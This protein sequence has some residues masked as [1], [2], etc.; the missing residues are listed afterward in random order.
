MN[1]FDIY[2]DPILFKKRNGDVNDP[3]KELTETIYIEK[4]CAHLTEIPNRAFGVKVTS[5]GEYM[6][7]VKD[8]PLKTNTYSVNYTNGLV[9]FH[10]SKN[11]KSL[12]FSYLGEGV[13]N[14][15]DSRIYLTEDKNF[16]TAK[17]KFADIDRGITEQKNRV[18]TLIRENPQPSE[19]VDMRIDRNGKVYPVA[20]DRVDAEQLKIE[21]LTTEINDS[22]KDLSGKTYNT[23]KDYHEHTEKKINGLEEQGNSNE[24]RIDDLEVLGNSNKDRI[25]DLEDLENSFDYTKIDPI[26]FTDLSLGAGTVLQWFGIDHKTGNMYATQVD[27]RNKNGGERYRL[28]RMSSTGVYLDSMLIEKGG[29]G[30]TV[31]MEWENGQLYFW[32]HWSEIDSSKK[33]VRHLVRFPYVAN[34]TLNSGVN[35]YNKFTD[36][37]VTPTIDYVNNFILFRV[38]LGDGTQKLELRR[39]SDVKNGI[40]NVLHS[41]TIPQR[42]VNTMQG[43][44]SDGYDIYWYNGSSAEPNNS[45]IIK[46]DIRTGKEIS[47]LN[48]TFGKGIDG[49]YKDGFREPEGIFIYIDPKTKKKSLFAGVVVGEIT[50]RIS[51]IYGFHQRGA[52]S[53]FDFISEV[54]SQKYPLTLANGKSIPFPVSANKISDVIQPGLYYMNTKDT[55]RVSDHPDPGDA[56]WFLHVYPGDISR[57]VVQK[58][59]RNSVVRSLRVFQRG[60]TGS[61]SVGRWDTVYTGGTAERLGSKIKKL[62]NCITPGKYYITNDEGLKYS[63]HP[64]PGSGGYWFDVSPTDTRDAVIQTMTLNSAVRG[65]IKYIRVV[66]TTVKQIGEW[67][68]MVSGWVD[69]KS[70][71]FKN[72]ASGD[73]RWGTDGTNLIIRGFAKIPDTDG[74]VFA[75][76]PKEIAP[77]YYWMT[78][79]AVTGTTGMRKIIYEAETRNLIASGIMAN[80][81]QNVDRVSLY[82]TIPRF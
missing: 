32:S 21:K 40:N 11:K 16:K 4:C 63:D 52:D 5:S 71:S 20:K 34:T 70:V 12:T 49:K 27:G 14:Y 29:H 33:E 79:T 57:T 67:Q 30:T 73:C 18:D 23:L 41:M 26:F 22:K 13:I 2:N 65:V 7:E 50:K 76:V 37:Y 28:T 6:Y 44:A 39:L 25:E 58:I 55:E 82:L 46:Y 53:K 56:G 47:R 31:G 45:W 81:T 9:Q 60:V 61:G 74:V 36:L 1:F 54:D 35:F 17:D 24:K 10:E 69:Y 78:M 66:A 77:K 51:K 75:T 43:V 42:D 38:T 62:S 3:Y 48:C 8:E 15:P 19:V 80:N 72:G 59:I 64:F 68:K